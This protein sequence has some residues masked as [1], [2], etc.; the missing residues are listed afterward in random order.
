MYECKNRTSNERALDRKIW[1]WKL[2]G[3]K[4][5]FSEVLGS[6]CGI[7]EWLEGFGIK[8]RGYCGV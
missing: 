3:V 7:L 8:D 6:I 1:P 4:W 2:L 5:S